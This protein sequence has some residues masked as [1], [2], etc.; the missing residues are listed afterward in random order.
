[1]AAAIG[2]V[3]FGG[4]E[5]LQ[6]SMRA[7]A[8]QGTYFQQW[9][10]ETIMQTVSA[11]DLREHPWQSLW[12]L[13]IQP[14]AL[15][16][17]R[18]ILAALWPGESGMELVRRVDQG[19][20]ILWTLFYAVSAVLV[21]RWTNELTSPVFAAGCALVYL[22]HPAHV[23]FTTFPDATLMTTTLVL[24]A[25]YE[26]WKTRTGSP[27]P[28]GALIAL[29]L[30]LFLARPVV[31]WPAAVVFA[32]SL[33]LL[34]VP[35]RKVVTFL[36]VVLCAMG[37][38]TLKQYLL[39]GLTTT[40]SF[41]GRNLC[42]SLGDR[43]GALVAPPD[44]WPAGCRVP[45]PCPSVLIRE[46][47]LDGAPNF[48]HFRYLALDRLLMKRFRELLGRQSAASLVRNYRQNI[49]LFFEPSSE[50]TTQAITDRLPWRS[51]YDRVFSYP[52]L[53]LLLAAAL[54][55]WVWRNRRPAFP[56][57]LA[58]ALPGGYLFLAAIICEK[59]EN[60]RF[61]YYLEP[62]IFVFLASQGY[63]LWLKV[64]S[65]TLRGARHAGAPSSVR[66]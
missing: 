49:R 29:V 11:Q 9:T 1:V 14:P 30:A 20:F 22:F 26:L 46:T 3:A 51:A 34:R 38:F 65:L 4:Q 12:Y 55:I 54:A 27:R 31:Q 10:S 44:Q 61:K 62:V 8:A 48:N 64:L 15:D 17:L 39:F 53:V 7:H 41:T 63:A 40:S 21:F 32:C 37:A 16:G 5:L 19:L 45:A 50:Y 66:L 2:L 58:M 24:W 25:Y 42:R 60:M 43:P 18:A 33:A 57:G 36:L 35:R 23:L 52:V 59:G 28:M 13:H 47:K 56:L 6:W